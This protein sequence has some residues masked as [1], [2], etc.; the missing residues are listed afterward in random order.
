MIEGEPEMI[1]LMKPF[2]PDQTE[3]YT[4]IFNQYGL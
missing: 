2:T 3:T 1:I 4:E